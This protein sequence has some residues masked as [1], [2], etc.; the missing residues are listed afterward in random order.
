M[1]TITEGPWQR[2]RSLMG[3]CQLSFVNQG[4]VF[5]LYLIGLPTAFIMRTM[6]A[7]AVP[8]VLDGIPAFLLSH[9]QRQAMLP[10]LEIMRLHGVALMSIF[11]LRTVVRFIGTLR[12]WNGHQ[13]G[14]HIYISAQL[15]GMLLPIMVAGPKTL[16]LFGFVIALNWCYLYFAQRK[17]LR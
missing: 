16:D 11:A 3:L 13:D 7:E 12:M 17:V 5:P 15:L 14:L 4:V 9:A 6:S 10:F 1:E 8:H 2:P